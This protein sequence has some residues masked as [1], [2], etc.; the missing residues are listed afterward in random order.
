[1]IDFNC[2]EYTDLIDASNSPLPVDITDVSYF[3]NGEIFNATLWLNSPLYDN[4]YADY[5]EANLSFFMFIYNVERSGNEVSHKL[6]NTVYIYPEQDGN[7]IYKFFENHPYDGSEERLIASNHNYNDL[8]QNGKRFVH[9]S[10]D[11]NSIGNPEEFAV[12]FQLSAET[13]Y[14][15][16]NFLK[17][18][19]KELLIDLTN[20]DTIPP[21]DLLITFD[22]PSDIKVAAGEGKKVEKPVSVNAL[23]L[24]VPERMMLSDGNKDDGINLS[25]NPSQTDLP[26]NGT[27][28]TKMTIETSNNL[29]PKIYD[30]VSVNVTR[31]IISSNSSELIN[32][33]NYNET[34]IVEI[35]NP[36]TLVDKLN[37]FLIHNYGLFIIPLGI[38]T[39]FAIFLSKRVNHKA[40]LDK[41]GIQDLLSI[42]GSVIVGV[43]IFLTL[44]TLGSNQGIVFT[45]TAILTATIVFPFALS[46]V[47]TLLG[48][49]IETGVKLTIPGFVYL[50]VSIVL[51]AYIQYQFSE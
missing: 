6:T 5:V 41:I 33:I 40:I 28:Y 44:G 20:W 30:A 48:R 10:L 50:M 34:V 25:F 3:S 45:L 9:I 22:A 49:P 11:V 1:M 19:G 7:W 35:L 38:T 18:K 37:N 4:R 46:A 39:V 17:D 42:D 23:D 26:L 36:L 16:L 43:L 47:T 8:Y 14:S 21:G 12:Q 2:L 27:K 31:G 24:N 51:V 15:G 29:Q 13:D 32:P